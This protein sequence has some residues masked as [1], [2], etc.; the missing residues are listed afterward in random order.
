MVCAHDETGYGPT[1][2]LTAGKRDDGGMIGYG[3]RLERQ[4][5]SAVRM[6]ASPSL[7]LIS[8]GRATMTFSVWAHLND[9]AQIRPA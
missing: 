9:G 6:P 7:A 2:A 1:N 8:G 5:R 3:L 4:Y